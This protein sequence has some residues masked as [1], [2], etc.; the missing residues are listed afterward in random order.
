M[1]QEQEIFVSE[2][3]LHNLHADIYPVNSSGTVMI[4]ETHKSNPLS[5]LVNILKT[6]AGAGTFALPW[7]IKQSGVI[8]GIIGI[9]LLAVISNYTMQ[10]LVK[11]RRYIQREEEFAGDRSDYWMIRKLRQPITVL[12]EGTEDEKRIYPKKSYPGVN[13]VIQPV[14][15]QPISQNYEEQTKEDPNDYIYDRSRIFTYVDLGYEAMGNLGAWIVYILM[16]TCNLGVCTVYLVFIGKLMNSMVP[17]FDLR[18]WMLLAMPI[19]LPMSWIRTYKFM[20]PISFFGIVSLMTALGSVI[21]YGFKERVQDMKW[22]WEYGTYSFINFSTLPL[23]FGVTLF[24]F[25]THA[26]VLP[27]EQSMRTRRYYGWTLTAGFMF[28]AIMNLA[29]AVLCFCFFGI[30]VADDVTKNLPADSAWVFVIKALLC[31][32]LVLTY[33][34]VLM[35]ISELVID[36]KVLK[37]VS[38]TDWNGWKFSALGTIGRSVLV[39]ITLII[40]EIFGSRFALVMSFIG[41]ISPNALGFI[42]PSL[43]YLILMRKKYGYLV[44]LINCVIILIG[45]VGMIWNSTLVVQQLLEQIKNG[46]F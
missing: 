2:E 19:L 6:F 26:M 41:G 40:G 43:F 10:L 35:P 7:A 44:F 14:L 1:E 5:A 11:C 33:G 37:K 39:L 28:I 30:E 24:L 42:M 9:V 3:G 31:A 25:N 34:V 38:T 23:F 12:N 20:S 17:T 15:S 36:Q 27:I 13:N 45:V 18:I 46:E 29:F 4:D 8:T 16:T 22:P 21:V 32:E